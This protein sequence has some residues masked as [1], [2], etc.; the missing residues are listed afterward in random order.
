LKGLIVIGNSPDELQFIR[1]LLLI[2]YF[3]KEYLLGSRLNGSESDD[4]WIAVKPEAIPNGEVSNTLLDLLIAF[5][6]DTIR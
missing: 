6:L 5:V 3:S 4:S 1:R 2:T